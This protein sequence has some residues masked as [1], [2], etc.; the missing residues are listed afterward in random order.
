M[1]DVI[2]DVGRRVIDAT[3]FADFGFLLDFRLVSVGEADG[4]AEKAL[5]DGAEN[6]GGQ[7]G[8]LVRAVRVIQVGDDVLE[9]L[10]SSARFGVSVSGSSA[11]PFS[12]EKWK[13]PE[14]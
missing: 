11:W 13:R 5:I 2:H 3:R 10:A 12:F 9:G 1:D 6:V 8:E 7:N 4:F 14:L